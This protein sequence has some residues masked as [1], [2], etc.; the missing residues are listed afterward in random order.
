LG[1]D[2]L[3]GLHT[4]DRILKSPGI[5]LKDVLYNPDPSTITS[6][7]DLFLRRYYRQVT[8]VT[9]TKGKSTTA[10]LIHHILKLEEK[11]SLLMGNIGR[12][13]FD[14]TDEI[15]SQSCSIFT[16]SILTH[17]PH[18]MIISLPR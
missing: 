18:S 5:T 15:T 17:M 14:F 2:Y 10:T 8:G 9:G 13:A 4:F 7:T 3:E 1:E 11:D 12:P 6:Q 16:R